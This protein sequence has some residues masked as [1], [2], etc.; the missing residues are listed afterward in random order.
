MAGKKGDKF[1]SMGGTGYHREMRAEKIEA[2]EKEK[3]ALEE[4]RKKG[5][6]KY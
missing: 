1:D 2:L 4:R 6:V 3:K 5:I